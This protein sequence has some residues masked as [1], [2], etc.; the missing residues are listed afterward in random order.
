MYALYSTLGTIAA[1][2]VQN[3]LPEYAWIA[4]TLA[5]IFTAVLGWMWLVNV[6]QSIGRINERALQRERAAHLIK[7]GRPMLSYHEMKKRNRGN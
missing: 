6:A 2:A 1:L 4:F 7:Y 3:Y 5:F